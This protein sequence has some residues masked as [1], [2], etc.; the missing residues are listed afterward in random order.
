MNANSNLL[1]RLAL[2]AA[3]GFVGT[4]VIQSLLRASMKWLPSTVPPM[5]GDPGEFM[6]HKAEEALPDTVREHIPQAVETIAGKA[7]GIGYGVAFGALYGAVRPR[8]GNVLTDGIVLGLTCWAAGYL[9]W[10]P[11]IEAMPPVWEQKP[12]QV[13]G[14]V[15]EH[16]AY[17]VVATETCTWLE[18]QTVG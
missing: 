10:L 14:P 15:V 17:G 1:R 4:L 3:G 18:R 16:L 7:L 6:V 5:R 13:L 9:G 12:A 2:G 8:G 11:A